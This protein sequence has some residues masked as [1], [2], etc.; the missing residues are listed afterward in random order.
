M[1][2]TGWSCKDKAGTNCQ[3]NQDLHVEQPSAAAC[4]QDVYLR[5]WCPVWAE[6]DES[7]DLAGALGGGPCG[8]TLTPCLPNDKAENCLPAWLNNLNKSTHMQRKSVHQP[9]SAMEGAM[10]QQ[11][12]FAN[13]TQAYSSYAQDTA[14]KI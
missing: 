3:D 13:T 1:S 7:S 10:W 14:A 5:P 8:H 12:A 11:T 6:C 9:A 4:M 2:P